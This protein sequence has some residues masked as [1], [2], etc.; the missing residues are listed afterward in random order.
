MTLASLLKLKLY[1]VRD[2]IRKCSGTLEMVYQ[3]VSKSSSRVSH[4]MVIDRHWKEQVEYLAP[5]KHVRKPSTVDA[6]TRKSDRDHH[7]VAEDPGH[8]SRVYKQCRVCKYDLRI[9]PRIGR[10]GQLLY[11]SQQKLH[12]RSLLGFPSCTSKLSYNFW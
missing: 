7:P 3:K 6:G 5:M 12:M 11:P 9:R 1:T 4:L 10:E 2:H 8:L